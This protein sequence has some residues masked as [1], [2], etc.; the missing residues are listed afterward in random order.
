MNTPQKKY[1]FKVIT[2]FNPHTFVICDELEV[3][4]AYFVFLFD[5]KTIINGRP[6]N[7]VFDII[8]HYGG[9][10]GYNPEYKFGTDPDDYREAESKGLLRKY[11]PMQN[12]I[13]SRVTY[14]IENKQQAQIGKGVTIP[15][16]ESKRVEIAGVAELT[17]KLKI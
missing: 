14:L 12:L 15:Q 4:K 7:K 10:L 16:L 8:P 1:Q 6:V 9:E 5:G 11:Q 2:G 17:K 13:Q 3:E